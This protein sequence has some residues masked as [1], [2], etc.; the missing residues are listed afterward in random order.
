MYQYLFQGGVEVV[1]VGEALSEPVFV[2]FDIEGDYI[3]GRCAHGLFYSARAG[4]LRI[5]RDIHIRFLDVNRV[6]EADVRF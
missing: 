3:V 6:A 1:Y 2:A 4:V 5:P